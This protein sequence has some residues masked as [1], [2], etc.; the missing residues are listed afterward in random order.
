MKVQYRI[1]RDTYLGYEVQKRWWIFPLWRQVG[2]TNTFA[3]RE[4]AERFIEDDRKRGGE[5][6]R[7]GWV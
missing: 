2:V 4:R 1:V 3:T 6:Y 7:T 5:V